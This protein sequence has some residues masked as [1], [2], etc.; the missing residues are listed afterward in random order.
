VAFRV[1]C[2][3]TGSKLGVQTREQSTSVLLVIQNVI[4]YRPKTDVGIFLD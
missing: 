2:S 3:P 4:V 1:D